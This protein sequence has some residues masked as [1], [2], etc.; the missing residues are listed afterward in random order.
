MGN[1][2]DYTGLEILGSRGR[3]SQFLSDLCCELLRWTKKATTRSQFPEGSEWTLA[4]HLAIAADRCKYLPFQD[5]VIKCASGSIRR[6]DLY[7]DG[8]DNKDSAFFE[9]KPGSVD[10]NT[11]Q[12]GS[13]KVLAPMKKAYSQLREI[14]CGADAGDWPAK[15][16]CCALGV[17][18]DMDWKDNDLWN[19]S[20]YDS[21]WIALK[22]KFQTTLNSSRDELSKYG[23]VYHCCYRIPYTRMKDYLKYAKEHANKQ[24]GKWNPPVGMLWVFSV[25]SRKE[26]AA[27]EK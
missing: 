5:A 7:I 10:L 19:K 8:G 6:P 3:K 26:I 1:T 21:A 4:G 11:K 25:R 23:R 16:G 17:I 14:A 18:V 13:I 2:W 9:L 24:G 12:Q 27:S 20:Q 22:T 15:W